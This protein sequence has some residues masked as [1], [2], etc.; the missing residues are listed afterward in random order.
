[1]GSLWQEDETGGGFCVF[2]L[3]EKDGRVWKQ[4]H[5]EAT[6]HH[7][8]AHPALSCPVCTRV[9]A[10]GSAPGWV[11]AICL[12]LLCSQLGAEGPDRCPSRTRRAQTASFPL[13]PTF[14]T[15]INSSVLLGS[16]LFF[17]FFFNSWNYFVFI[18]R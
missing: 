14:G 6:L 10:S 3:V 12:R 7:P 5:G 15:Y 17:L 2:F 1:M 8:A 18:L 9:P 4:V 11:L 16:D 13:R